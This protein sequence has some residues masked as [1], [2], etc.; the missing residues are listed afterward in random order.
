MTQRQ[1]RG[2]TVLELV[3][4]LSMVAVLLVIMFS[5]LRIGLMA[6]SRGEERAAVLEH[7]RSL[8]QLLDQALAGSFPY[9]GAPSQGE[10]PRI[11]F[12]GQPDR[13]IFVT[14]S[15]PFPAPVPI[16]FM[17]VTLSLDPQ[18]LALR[19]QVL[20]N[21]GP[22]DRLTPLVVD[23]AVTG[24]HFRYLGDGPEAWQEHWDM[25]TEDTLPRAVEI[26]L[27]TAAGSRRIEQ[28]SFLFPIRAVVVP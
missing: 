11:L 8:A 26:T 9:L 18:G 1:H 25:S 13:L 24:V 22:L 17:S 3:I 7:R 27:T 28:A 4:A 21:Q 23:P 2:F 14:L 12:D 19:Q 15:P 20:P 16:A 5:S 6:W 10:E